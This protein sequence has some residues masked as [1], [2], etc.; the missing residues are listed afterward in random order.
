MDVIS[1]RFQMSQVGEG[2]GG[3][4]REGRVRGSRPTRSCDPFQTAGEV[5]EKLRVGIQ[6]EDG[7]CMEEVGGDRRDRLQPEYG[8]FP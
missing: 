8:Q 1:T 6:R 5:K 2:Q 4:V 7:L 3:G